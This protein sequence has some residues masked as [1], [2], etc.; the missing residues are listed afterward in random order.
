MTNDR[1]A[2]IWEFFFDFKFDRAAAHIERIGD[3]ILLELIRVSDVDNHSVAA[4]YL[5]LGI[6]WRNFG[7]FLF[8]VRDQVLESLALSHKRSLT[9]NGRE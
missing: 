5:Q 4:L 6:G 9:M 3:V 2:A 1:R 8:R 7:D